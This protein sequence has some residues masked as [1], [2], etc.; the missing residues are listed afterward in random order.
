MALLFKTFIIIP[1]SSNENYFSFPTKNIRRNYRLTEKVFFFLRRKN[2]FQTRREIREKWNSNFTHN[3]WFHPR[4][5]QEHRCIDLVPCEDFLTNLFLSGECAE[6]SPWP[7]R[8]TFFFYKFS[9]NFTYVLLLN[10]VSP[11]FYSHAFS[12][13]SSSG[14]NKMK[15]VTKVNHSRTKNYIKSGQ[16]H[17]E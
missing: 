8:L 4:T 9:Y 6:K 13:F 7:S 17:S 3:F 1:C 16:I 11:F 15:E 14:A 12:I 2:I 5:R 10:S